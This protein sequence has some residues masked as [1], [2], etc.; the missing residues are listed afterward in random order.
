M[1]SLVTC[2]ILP[3]R[4]VL[5]PAP[6]QYKCRKTKVEEKSQVSWGWKGSLRLSSP[7]SLL[8]KCHVGP[9]A[10]DCVQ[11]ALGYFWGYSPQPLWAT[12]ASAPSPSQQK[13]VSWCSGGTSCVCAHCLWFCPWAPLKSVWLCPFMHLP[14]IYIVYICTSPLYTLMWPPELSLSGSTVPA[15]SAFP[16][17]SDT[18]VPLS[19]SWPI[20]GCSPRCPCSLFH[21]GPQN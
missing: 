3:F 15:F 14:F 16:H 5:C 21:C 9:V 1:F 13:S 10:Q 20:V 18:S 11:K 2:E 4:F 17:R 7:T 19:S 12:S 8:N 6:W